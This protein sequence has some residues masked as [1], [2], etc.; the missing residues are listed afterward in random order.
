MF[1]LGA[2]DPMVEAQTRGRLSSWERLQ[3]AG[4]EA[5]GLHLSVAASLREPHPS[6]LLPLLSILESTL[7]L[8][9]PAHGPRRQMPLRFA[10]PVG[11]CVQVCVQQERACQPI[12][13]YSCV[14]P[15]PQTPAHAHTDGACLLAQHKAQTTQVCMGNVCV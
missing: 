15:D 2:G 14:H 9:K 7:V 10:V 3:G 8:P 13:G 1:L 4:V 11:S 5:G 6:L 12:Q